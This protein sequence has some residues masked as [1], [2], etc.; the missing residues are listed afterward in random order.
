[1]QQER[2]KRDGSRWSSSEGERWWMGAI[3]YV[4]G[5]LVT[6]IGGAV[7]V[8]F[9]IEDA[10]LILVAIAI[11]GGIILAIHYLLNGASF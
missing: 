2:D 1:V 8:L 9:L 10:W 11:I 3:T 4:G 5:G 6:L 7:V